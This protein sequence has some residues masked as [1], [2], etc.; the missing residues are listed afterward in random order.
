MKVSYFEGLANHESPESC[1]CAGNF[2]CEALTGEHRD[3]TDWI[4]TKKPPFFDSN[5]YSPPIIGHFAKV[6]MKR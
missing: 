1:V 4:P 6:I 2:M 5:I 3:V